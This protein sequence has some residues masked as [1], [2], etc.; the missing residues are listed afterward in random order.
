MWTESNPNS[1]IR[2]E[3][4]IMKIAVLNEPYF[5]KQKLQI[6]INGIALQ[7]LEMENQEG[8]FKNTGSLAG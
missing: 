7:H 2:E 6:K 8:A 5:P 4:Q 1:Q 3:K